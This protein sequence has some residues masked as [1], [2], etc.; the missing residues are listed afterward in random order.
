MELNLN[1]GD[2]YALLTALCWSSAVILFKVST[3]KLGNLQINLF[4]NTIGITGFIS[5]LLIQGN[6]FPDFSSREWIILILSG[7]LGIAIGDL[8][9]LACLRKLGAGLSAIVGTAYSPAIFLFAFLMFNES[10]SFQTYFGGFLVI[11]GII[12]GSLK[13]P[14]DRS[15]KDIAWGILYGIAAQT[16]TAFSVLFVRP[17]MD[18]YDI[19]PIAMVRFSAGVVLSIGFITFSQG[20]HSLKDTFLTGFKH[21]PLLIGSILGSFISVIFW[22][23]GFKYTLA[24]R[25]AVYN[26]LSTVLI[27]LMAGI[28]LKEAMTKRKWLAVATAL[29]GAFIISTS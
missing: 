21:I 5:V 2:I 10:I 7:T 16:L 23:A 4:K 25:A 24:G 28:F 22:L 15:R 8:F 14:I 18:S 1:L 11:S 20:I 26:Q 29:T 27:I 3:R 6:A 13:I 12:I 9:F 19:V 17:L